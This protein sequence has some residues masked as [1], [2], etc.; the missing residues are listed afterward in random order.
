[1][2]IVYSEAVKRVPIRNSNSYHFLLTLFGSS[3]AMLLW[4]IASW[5]GSM[6][7]DS[8]D[9]L[10]QVLTGSIRND[11]PVF[12][13]IWVKVLSLN[14]SFLGGVMVC[15]A[16]LMSFAISEIISKVARLRNQFL[17][18]IIG[19]LTSIFPHTGGLAVSLIKDAPYTI[20][21]LLG[22]AMV[23]NGADTK[24]PMSRKI[25]AF[26]FLTI[27]SLFR[28]EGFF[29]LLLTTL[30]L[31][32]L[33]KVWKLRVSLEFVRILLVSALC[34]LGLQT[35][36]PTILGAS[37]VSPW[38]RNSSFLIDVAFIEKEFPGT[39]GNTESK[40]LRKN[41]P[42][43]ASKTLDNCKNPDPFFFT[44]GVD[45]SSYNE[46]T[47][48]VKENWLQSLKSHPTS[49]LAFRF[50]RSYIFFP[51]IFGLSTEGWWTEWGIE[52]NYNGIS[53]D[54]APIPIL[55]DLFSRVVAFF[56][57]NKRFFAYPGIYSF[58]PAI[59]VWRNQRFRSHHG[60]I[61]AVVLSALTSL[62]AFLW[63]S[64]PYYRY[65]SFSLAFSI[66]VVLASLMS[67]KDRSS[68]KKQ[69]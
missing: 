47:A 1:M 30:M 22:V 3:I 34:A 53:I 52:E 55:T 24:I 49:L 62:F 5:P 48:N 40:L 10:N 50:C 20:F 66:I 57:S 44:T 46:L 9:V 11:H 12:N 4:V 31:L 61:A 38:L 7:N 26:I 35:A 42:L 33:Y 39:L 21:L 32:I 43:E 17:Y 54:S 58:I 64:G 6:G 41:V 67:L 23:I 45:L 56:E 65:T 25:L 63:G 69:R 13:Y 60:V 36:L 29:I 18:A 68:S 51:P 19:F 37:E 8:Q 16:F 27:S 14:G 28:H 15:Q 2:V 59:F